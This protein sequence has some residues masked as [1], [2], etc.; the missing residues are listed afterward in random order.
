VGA[1]VLL[2]LLDMGRYVGGRLKQALGVGLRVG[3]Y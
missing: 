3:F 2:E 1:F